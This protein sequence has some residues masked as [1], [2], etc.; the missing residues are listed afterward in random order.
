M[1]GKGIARTAGALCV[2]GT[3]AAALSQVAVAR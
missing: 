1:K 2:V 3:A